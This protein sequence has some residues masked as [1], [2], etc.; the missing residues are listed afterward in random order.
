MKLSKIKPN[1]NNP[2]QITKDALDRLAESIN[3]DPE[4]MEIRPI[5]IDKD[6]VIV[7]GNQRYNAIRQLGMTDIPDTWVL[8]ADTLTPEQI[9]RFILVDNSIPGMSGDW[10]VDLLANEWEL[11][12]LQDLGFNL[13]DLG[14]SD[15][16]DVCLDDEAKPQN[17]E[18]EQTIVCPK[19]GFEVKV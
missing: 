15:G 5:V 16:D 2:R 7:G 11:P 8:R 4:F 9:R 18:D 19:C 14:L 1:P 3:R 17:K 10:D 6:N 12:E 13:D